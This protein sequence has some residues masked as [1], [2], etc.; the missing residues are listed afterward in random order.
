MG[1]PAFVIDIDEPNTPLNHP[2]SQQA[3]TG[4]RGFVRIATVQIERFSGLTLQV[5]QF[6]GR[7]L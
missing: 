2:A 1:I 4:E 3:G 5:H 7:G 6:R